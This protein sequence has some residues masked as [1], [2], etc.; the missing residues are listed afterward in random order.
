MKWIAVLEGFQCRFML[1]GRLGTPEAAV[2]GGSLPPNDVCRT[3]GPSTLR[4][5]V[6]KTVEI[7]NILLET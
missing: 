1:L 2:A 4:L 5:P 3:T 7:V 6:L